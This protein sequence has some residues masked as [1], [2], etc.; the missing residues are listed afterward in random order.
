MF[1]FVYVEETICHF[2]NFENLVCGL[3]PYHW[4]ELPKKIWGDEAPFLTTASLP[5]LSANSASRI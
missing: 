3:F 4:C 1:D 5:E 2:M